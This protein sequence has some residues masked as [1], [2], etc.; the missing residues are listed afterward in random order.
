M[1]EGVAVIAAVRIANAWLL[2]DDGGRR[3]LID[4]GHRVERRAL[5][6]GLLALGVRGRGDLE[7]VL[8]THRHS[9]HAG[10]ARFIRERYGCDV[11]CH[12]DDAA[13]LT[14]GR[15]ATPLS[16]RGAA[17][18]HDALCRIEDSFP[19]TTPVDETFTGG[20]FR[21]GFR[22]IE[23]AGHTEGSVLLLHEPS[24]TLFTGDALLTGVPAQR[25][26]TRLALA[27]AEYSL[28][29]VACRRAVLDF[30]DEGAKIERVCSGHGPLVGRDV[31]NRLARFA[32]RQRRE[33]DRRREGKR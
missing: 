2:T 29:V 9:D 18:V 33:L 10:N 4:S 27:F 17:M 12:R 7:A 24:G 14:G 15:T 26:H 16:R 20:S 32:G 6:R 21:W 25:L 30:L 31:R 13:V 3:F 28:D 19:A 5:E 1:T 22:V 8:L 23:V 11:I